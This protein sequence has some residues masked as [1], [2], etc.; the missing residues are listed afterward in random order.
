NERHP[1]GTGVGRL[2][3]DNRLIQNY[4]TENILNYTNTFG[5]YTVSGLLGHS[6]QKLHSR[7]SNI[8]AR[9]FPTPSLG[10]V[11]V[12]SEI[13]SASGAPS[14][15][16]LESYFGRATVSYEDKYMF[17][18]TLRADGSSKFR[19]DNRWGVFPSLSFGWNVSKEQFMDGTD[20]DLKLRASYGKTGNQEGIGNYAYQPLIAGGQ[21]Y[22]GLSGISVSTFGNENLTWEKADQYD[23]GFDISL[24][25]RRVN[26][27]LDAYYKKTTDLL[28]SMP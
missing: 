6:F 21:N 23:L 27:S 4:L 22:G 11:S 1:Y 26:L 8:D 19:S 13:T 15:Y 5:D 9:G 24:F 18:G 16:A 14:E 12:A 2:L 28:Y 20:L 10:V 25:K 17:T 7:N 3:D